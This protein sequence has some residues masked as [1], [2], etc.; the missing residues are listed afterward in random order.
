[1][2]GNGGILIM[3]DVLWIDSPTGK[4][5]VSWCINLGDGREMRMNSI[6]YWNM[7]VTDE[8]LKSV[9]RR[10]YRDAQNEIRKIKIQ[11]NQNLGD[12]NLEVKYIVQHLKHIFRNEKHI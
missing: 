6:F 11:E 2:M 12:Q 4:K 8:R 5:L 3:F 1:M 9:N 10:K 7:W